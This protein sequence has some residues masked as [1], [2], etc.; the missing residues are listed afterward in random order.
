MSHTESEL[1]C[2]SDYRT[3]FQQERVRVDMLLQIA[4][5]M[6][7]A[8]GEAETPAGWKSR[9]SSLYAKMDTGKLQ[10][11]GK[12]A[13]GKYYFHTTV[14]WRDLT[15]QSTRWT[16]EWEWVRRPCRAWAKVHEIDLPSGADAALGRP[17]TSGAEAKCREWL[18]GL[19]KDSP[20][21]GTKAK[22]EYTAE[23]RK[24]FDV[25]SKGFGRSWDRAIE[26]T[27]ATG[28]SKSGPKKTRGNS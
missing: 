19:M 4:A 1:D 10:A 3:V 16:S 25:G 9:K 20:S 17:G 18:R 6:A 23:A 14:L 28:W 7:K 15:L 8:A 11:L 13:D 2:L 24:L 26:D 21:G 22:A 12:N 27:G 5:C